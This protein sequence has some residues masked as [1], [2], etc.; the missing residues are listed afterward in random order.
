MTCHIL[1]YSCIKLTIFPGNVAGT[2]LGFVPQQ[3]EGT[4]LFLGNYRGIQREYATKI[5]M[6]I[7]TGWVDFVVV[8]HAFTVQYR[9]CF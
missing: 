6:Y 1:F 8:V 2:L 3:I 4:S 9:E 7:L 5:M